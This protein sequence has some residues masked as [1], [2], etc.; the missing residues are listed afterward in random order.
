MYGSRHGLGLVRS[1]S[2]GKF[3]GDG[4]C[5]VA[6]DGGCDVAEGDSEESPRP[7]LSSFADCADPPLGIGVAA[8]SA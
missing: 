2:R 7:R 8:A 5:D 3:F 4:G 1:L 6:G